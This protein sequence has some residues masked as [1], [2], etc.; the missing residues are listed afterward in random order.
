MSILSSN[1]LTYR[2]ITSSKFQNPDMMSASLIVID[3]FDTENLASNTYKALLDVKS[4]VKIDFKNMHPWNVTK[5]VPC[6]I[7][8]NDEF[9][10]TLSTL[11]VNR[12]ARYN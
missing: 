10:T 5:D 8:T 2:F 6:V 9:Y 11:T 4:A 1:I 7:S 3:E 12:K